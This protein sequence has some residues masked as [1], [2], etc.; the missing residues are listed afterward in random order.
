VYGDNVKVMKIDQP[1]KEMNK[2]HAPFFEYGFRYCYEFDLAEYGYTDMSLYFN[3]LF[4]HE[5]KAMMNY[6]NTI[7]ADGDWIMYAKINKD[8]CI[9]R[10]CFKRKE[11]LITAM[12]MS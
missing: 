10:V 7:Y 8:N 1:L 9:L 4:R 12:L 11:T 2:R 5:S 3:N 6:D